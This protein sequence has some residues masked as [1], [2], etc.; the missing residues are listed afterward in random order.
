MSGLT[1]DL[2]LLLRKK[3]LDWTGPELRQAREVLQTRAELL[4]GQLLFAYARLESKLDLCLVWVNEGKAYDARAKD[5]ERISF[6]NKLELLKEDA[7]HAPLD[8]SSAYMD[9]VKRSHALREKR[10]T[11]VHGRIGFDVIRGI[12][13]VVSSRATSTILVSDEY[14]LDELEQVVNEAGRLADDLTILRSTFP[15]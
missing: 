12:V 11:L 3:R 5:V 1:F 2:D 7:R 10:N 9:W 13:I 4:L 8:C 14:S 15:L 6:F